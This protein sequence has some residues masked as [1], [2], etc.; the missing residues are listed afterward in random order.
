MSIGSLPESRNMKTVARTVRY[1]EN[2]V[3][4]IREYATFTGEQEAVLLA[5]ASLCGL[6]EERLER[7]LMAYL[8][9]A[10]S[11]EAAHIAGVGRHDFILRA[12]ERGM[13]VGDT[14]P[15]TLLQDISRIAD[16]M[17]DSRLA[18]VVA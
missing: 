13:I 4:E 18:N 9:G 10:S 14:E 17:G 12:I 8:G 15:D 6:R 7:G 1:T 16:I 3:R 11:S 5:R 2:E